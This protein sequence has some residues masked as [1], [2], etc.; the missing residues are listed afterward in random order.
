MHCL[1]EF[2]VETTI[3]STVKKTS[4][5]TYRVLSCTCKM[6]KHVM[7]TKYFMYTTCNTTFMHIF[8]KEILHCIA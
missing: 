8:K 7:T 6:E 2:I 4:L 3:S 1:S 5:L